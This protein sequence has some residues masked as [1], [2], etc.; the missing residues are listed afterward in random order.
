MTVNY[1]EY[2]GLTYDQVHEK[3]ARLAEAL[4]KPMEI[5][6]WYRIHSSYFLGR[7]KLLKLSIE[8]ESLQDILGYDS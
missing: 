2:D 7:A 5:R 1:F 4:E 3:V 6:E 8:R